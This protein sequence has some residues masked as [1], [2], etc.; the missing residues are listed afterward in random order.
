MENV[1]LFQ[2]PLIPF[3]LNPFGII[4]NIDGKIGHATI[5]FA[6]IDKVENTKTIIPQKDRNRTIIDIFSY[7]II[8]EIEIKIRPR[9]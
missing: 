1:S 7:S 6:L 5:K 4:P 3:Q 9:L 2:P 8:P